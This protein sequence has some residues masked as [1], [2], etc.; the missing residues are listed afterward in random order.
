MN[1]KLQEFYKYKTKIVRVVDADTVDAILDLGFGV[2][3]SRRFR[4]ANFDAPETWRPQNDKEEAHGRN[5]TTRALELL[6]NKHVI[7]TTSKQPGIYG[8]YNAKI[9]L[10]DG[11]DYATIMINEGFQKKESY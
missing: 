9:T 7:F 8:R 6:S 1:N 10:E 2:K 5:A 11:N 3:I 4:V